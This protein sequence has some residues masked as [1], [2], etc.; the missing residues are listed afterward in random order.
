MKTFEVSYEN[1]DRIKVECYKA[2]QA[3]IFA[4]QSRYN[5]RHKR[6]GRVDWVREVKE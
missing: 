2:S 4:K 5:L 3:Y 6:E 1:G